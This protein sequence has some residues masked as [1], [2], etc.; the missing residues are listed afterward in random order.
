MTNILCRLGLHKKRFTYKYLPSIRAKIV[1]DYITNIT[2]TRCGKNLVH[3]HLIWD[4]KN[5][6]ERPCDD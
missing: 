2:C 3:R 4:G 1:T 5:M 6:V